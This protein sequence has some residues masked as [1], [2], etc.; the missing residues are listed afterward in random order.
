M[1]RLSG[2]CSTYE[3]LML[4][5]FHVVM[6]PLSGSCGSNHYEHGNQHAMHV[7]V[8]ILKRVLKNRIRY[9]QIQNETLSKLSNS[10]FFR[11]RSFEI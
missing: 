11:I 1:L 5:L 9:F 10:I 2:V 7:K 6:N 4:L 8:R 3:D